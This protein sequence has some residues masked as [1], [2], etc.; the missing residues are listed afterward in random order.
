M[1]A[2]QLSAL[3]LGVLSTA[4]SVVASEAGKTDYLLASRYSPV[5]RPVKRGFQ[6]DGT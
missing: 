3:A 2:F 5:G 1:L 6:E 4:T